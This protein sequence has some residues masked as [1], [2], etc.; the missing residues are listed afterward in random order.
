MTLD[1]STPGALAANACYDYLTLEVPRGETSAQ[2]CANSPRSAGVDPGEPGR[3]TLMSWDEIRSIAA[4]PL[5]SIGAHT[6]NHYNL[7]RLPEERA[8]REMTDVGA[9]C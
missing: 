7:K 9:P 3:K 4:H 8:K 1:C 6:V 2:R 5:V